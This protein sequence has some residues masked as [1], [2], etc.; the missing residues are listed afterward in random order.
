M[1]QPIMQYHQNP[2]PY[3]VYGVQPGNVQHFVR[4]QLPVH[5]SPNVMPMG[6]ANVSCM[7]PMFLS[8][9]MPGATR[10]SSQFVNA[11]FGS[12]NVS[13]TDPYSCHF[14]AQLE[15]SYETG[16]TDTQRV[17]VELVDGEQYA[18]VRRKDD[19]GE[20]VL[21][22]LIHED[23]KRFRLCSLEGF[24]LAIMIKGK[25][26]RSSVTWYSNDGSQMVWHRTQDVTF[27]LV[28]ITPDQSRRNSLASNLSGTSQMSCSQASPSELVSDVRMRIRPELRRQEEPSHEKELTVGEPPKL[29]SEQLDNMS[30]GQS[31][32]SEGKSPTASERKLTDDELFDQL[33][34]C[35]VKC[36]SLL[37]KIVHWGITRTPNRRVGSNDIAGFAT[38]RIWVRASLIEPPRG[39]TESWQEVLNEF[40]GAYQEAQPDVFMQP[41]S[42]PNEP[43]R[44]HRIRRNNMGFWVIEEQNVDANVWEPCAQELPYGHWVDLKDNRRRYK[45][46]LVPMLSILNRMQEHWTDH[47]EMERS[48]DFLFN[49]CN[50][51]KLNTRLKARNLKHNISN[52]RLKLEKQYALS[53]AVRVAEI[54]DSIALEG[55]SVGCTNTLEKI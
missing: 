5:L 20:L 1:Y 48:I 40:K 16:L 18:N 38:G 17:Q 10:N 35:C 6:Q 37:E 29:S 9:S 27:K 36:P 13:S 31:P 51:K 26:M 54:A 23:E 14:L 4:P 15:G 21:T 28:T 49:S 46:Q 39:S 52:L 22:Q 43:G 47:E 34:R 45:I 41:P 44:R 32:L 55:Q 33:K 25:D 53:F 3:Q 8:E 11:D 12:S 30:S 24:V 7:P 42:Q 19:R 50:Q 2:S